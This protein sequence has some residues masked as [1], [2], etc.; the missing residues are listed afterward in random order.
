VLGL[1]AA[2]LP[3]L[4][5][6]ERFLAEVVVVLGAAAAG[7]VAAPAARAARAATAGTAALDAVHLGGREAQARSDLVGD[8]LDDAALLAL[9]GLPAALLEAAG[10]HDARALLQRS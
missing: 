1:R 5:H 9:L 8:D 4:C 2:A 7:G 10:D 6:L 3:A